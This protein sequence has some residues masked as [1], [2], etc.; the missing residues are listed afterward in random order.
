MIKKLNLRIDNE[1]KQYTLKQIW[2]VLII[3]FFFFGLFYY[4]FGLVMASFML[5]MFLAFG[6]LWLYLD[7][8]FMYRLQK[9]DE[10]INN[11]KYIMRNIKK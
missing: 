4:N 5:W 9:Q 7:V 10:E 3:T 1:F 2:F 6:V 8:K 11:L